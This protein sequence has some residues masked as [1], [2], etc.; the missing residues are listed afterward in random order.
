MLYHFCALRGYASG[1]A[2]FCRNYDYSKDIYTKIKYLLDRVDRNDK[3]YDKYLE[4]NEFNYEYINSS[5]YDDDL[6][7]YRSKRLY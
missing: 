4:N 6:F 2:L 7:K 1:Y 3:R 5:A